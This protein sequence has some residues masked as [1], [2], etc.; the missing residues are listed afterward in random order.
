[1]EKK[2]RG[3]ESKLSLRML[4]L[5]GWWLIPLIPAD[6]EGEAEAERQRHRGK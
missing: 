4:G 6:R 2:V 5:L 3:K 1:M